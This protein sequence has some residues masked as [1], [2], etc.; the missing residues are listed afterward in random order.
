MKQRQIHGVKKGI[1]L[2]EL[3]KSHL[4]VAPLPVGYMFIVGVVVWKKV[5]LLNNQNNQNQLKLN[6]NLNLKA[7]LKV[8]KEKVQS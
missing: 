2:M 7:N 1:V 5:K 8:V 4:L 3:M 6:Q